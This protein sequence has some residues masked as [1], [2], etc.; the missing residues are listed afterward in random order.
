MCTFLGKKFPEAP[1]PYVNDVTETK[2]RSAFIVRKAMLRSLR[3]LTFVVG[4]I[5]VAGLAVFWNSRLETYLM[6]VGVDPGFVTNK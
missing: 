3:K 4:P 1:F 5:A 2:R 6:E